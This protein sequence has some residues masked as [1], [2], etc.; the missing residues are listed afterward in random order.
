VK[1][2]LVDTSVWVDH[3]RRHN[4]ALADLLAMDLVHCHP[5]VLGE[6]ACGSPPSRTQTLADLARLPST[7]QA[8]L[9]EVLAFI[10][11]EQLFG[12]GCGF[13]DITLLAST[14]LTPGAELWTLDKRLAALAERAGVLHRPALH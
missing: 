2:V 5:L 11:R 7:Q 9:Q 4:P 12:L 1:P 13:V 3:F 14:L 8:N 10:E 6:I